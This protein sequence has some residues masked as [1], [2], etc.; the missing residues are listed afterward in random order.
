MSLNWYCSMKKKFGKIRIIFDIENW[1][2]KSKFCNFWQRLLNWMQDLFF[3][4]LVIGLKH[5]GSPCKMCDKSWV[6]RCCWMPSNVT[7]LLTLSTEAA[8]ATAMKKAN[9]NTVFIIA[10]YLL[11]FLWRNETLW[12]KELTFI[13]FVLSFLS[14]QSPWKIY[15]WKNLRNNIGLIKKLICK[16]KA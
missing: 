10:S 13:W 15:I 7:I 4:G 8:A 5:K 1:L 12:E 16:T 2:W 14:F 6:I 9:T 3:K 11:V